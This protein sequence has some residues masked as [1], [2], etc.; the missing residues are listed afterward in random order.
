M[1][2]APLVVAA[3]LALTASAVRAGGLEPS[4]I[5]QQMASDRPGANVVAPYHSDA[6]VRRERDRVSRIIRD[7]E[8]GRRV[9]PDQIDWAVRRVQDGDL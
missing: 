8:A 6:A 7:L 5:S 1:R 4:T 9:P 2:I 3:A